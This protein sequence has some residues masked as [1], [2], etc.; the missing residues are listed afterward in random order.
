MTLRQKHIRIT[1]LSLFAFIGL[2]T[3]IFFSQ[4]MGVSK[5]VDLSQ[6]EATILQNPRELSPFALTGIDG[7]AYTNESLEGQWTLMFFGFTSCGS[8]CPT[9]MAKLAAA[10]TLLK[11]EAIEPL[12]KVV[13]ISLDPKRDSLERLNAYVKSFHPAFF[14]A[15]G[16][17]KLVRAMTKELGIV[18]EK[19]IAKENLPENYDIQHSGTVM[20]INP[21]GQIAGFF[22]MPHKAELIAKDYNLLIHLG[23]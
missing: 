14:A 3:G 9:T 18:Y 13:M 17:A 12:P 2:I 11:K 7:K 23:N 20:I 6:F 16:E 19:V 21:K 15:Y 10:Y 1:V 5:K 4:A 8:I 22:S